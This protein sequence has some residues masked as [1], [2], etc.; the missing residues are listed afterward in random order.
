MTETLM[1]E[2]T[3]QEKSLLDQ[4]ELDAKALSGHEHT[5]QNG[6]QVSQL[7]RLLISRKAI[8]T[9][10]LSWFTDAS[11]NIGGHGSSR[12]E[13]FERNGTIGEAIL[14]HPHFLAH[15]RYFIHGPDLPPT[16]RQEFEAQVAECGQVTSGDIIPLGKF[17]R[18]QVRARRLEPKKAAEEFFKL[19]IECGL[20]P[21]TATSIREQVRTVR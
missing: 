17:A 11:Y 20:G 7:M 16:V 14:R 8:S 5:L 6:E 10:R 12:Q 3:E 2:L 21:E 4:I 1:I 18:Q 9:D 15:F 13:I 19:A